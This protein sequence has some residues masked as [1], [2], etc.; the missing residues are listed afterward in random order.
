MKT[1]KISDAEWQV[2]NEVWSRPALTGG[3]LIAA[4]G[5]RC[6]W[7]PRTIRTLLDRLVGKGALKVVEDG[8]R[9]FVPAVSREA[10]VHSESRSFMDRVFG[11]EPAAMLL[12]VIKE[13]KLTPAEINQLKKMLTEKEK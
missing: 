6:A 12:H 11:G 1:V 4:I 7:R 5:S 2:M 8:K 13:S 3:E 9:R 10:C